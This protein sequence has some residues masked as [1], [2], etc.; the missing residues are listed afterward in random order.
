[1]YIDG[2]PDGEGGVLVRIA[3]FLAR[4]EEGQVPE[5]L[6][7]YSHSPGLLTAFGLMKWSLDGPVDLPNRIQKLAITR[8]ARVLNCDF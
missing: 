3:R 8:V 6:R 2:V 7:A 1:M 4:R 5:P